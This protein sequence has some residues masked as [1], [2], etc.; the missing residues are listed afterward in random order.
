MIYLDFLQ[1][2]NTKL[3][4]LDNSGEIRYWITRFIKNYWFSNTSRYY[5]TYEKYYEHFEPL[6]D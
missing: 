1:Y 2:D 3:N 5:S 4:E 6:E